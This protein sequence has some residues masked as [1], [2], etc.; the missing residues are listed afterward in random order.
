MLVLLVDDDPM[1]QTIYSVLLQAQGHQ[2]ITAENG[3]A[4]LARL[5]R[6]ERLPDLILLDLMMPEMDGWT[7]RQAQR[8][9]PDLSAIPVIILSAA[10]D[11]MPRAETMGVAQVL[12]KPINP[13]LLLAT[14]ARYGT[15]A[16]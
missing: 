2:V 14:V 12:Q 13:P 4:A 9:D 8:S 1:I 6:M 15:H 11:L 5:R 3:R 16:A 10:A 7:F